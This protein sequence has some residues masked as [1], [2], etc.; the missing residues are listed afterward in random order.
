MVSGWITGKKQ[1]MF[2]PKFGL[3]RLER[4][5]DSRGLMIRF[6]WLKDQISV[7]CKEGLVQFSDGT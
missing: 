3:E 5:S 1:N 7:W 4:A 6:V 2:A